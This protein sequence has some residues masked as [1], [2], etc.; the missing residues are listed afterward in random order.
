MPEAI[1]TTSTSQSA[2]ES[3]PPPA[4][5]DFPVILAA[6][7]SDLEAGVPISFNYPLLET[8]NILEKLGG[9]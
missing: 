8:P 9:T 1:V 6:N 5:P 7:L 2:G 4:T 3:L